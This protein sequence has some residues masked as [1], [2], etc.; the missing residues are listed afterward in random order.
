MLELRNFH[1]EEKDDMDRLNAL[2]EQYYTEVC[3]PE[4]LAQEIADLYDEELNAQLLEQTRSKEA[5][6]F[7]MSIEQDGIGIGFISY[8]IYTEKQLCFINNFYI[9]PPQRNRGLGTAAYGLAEQHAR[10][11]GVLFVRLEP[12]K[13]AIPFYLRSGFEKSGKTKEGE[14]VLCKA[15]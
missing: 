6:H 7:I 14:P 9:C 12:E 8:T 11:L 3:P 5:P 10:R 2:Y 13:R 1:L 15:L 4:E